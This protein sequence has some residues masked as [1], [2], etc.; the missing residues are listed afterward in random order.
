MVM[1][2]AFAGF[3]VLAEPVRLNLGYVGN[4][5]E[6]VTKYIGITQTMCLFYD[7]TMADCVTYLSRLLPANDGTGT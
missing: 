5:K 7:W 3:F 4:L 1:N 6:V 2:F